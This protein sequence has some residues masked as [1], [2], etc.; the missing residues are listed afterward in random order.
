MGLGCP[1]WGIFGNVSDDNQHF[2]SLNIRT[3]PKN[4]N[5]LGGNPQRGHR[6]GTAYVFIIKDLHLIFIV[7]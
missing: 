7:L 4:S 2:I 1:Y 5:Q 3:L 6:Q